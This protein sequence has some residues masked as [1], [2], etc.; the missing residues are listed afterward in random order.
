VHESAYGRFCWR[1]RHADGAGRLVHFLKPFIVTRW[2]V[3]EAPPDL[4]D[5]GPVA[6]YMPVAPTPEMG[7]RV[8]SASS[9][10]VAA[11]Q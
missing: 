11:Q 3:R 9:A 6:P 1:N 5:P 2:I 4:T 8:G 7:K 10:T